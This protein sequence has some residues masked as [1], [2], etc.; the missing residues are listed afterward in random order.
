M[1]GSLQEHPDQTTK[2]CIDTRTRDIYA[3]CIF[4]LP[5]LH[6]C[7]PHS[8]QVRLGAGIAATFA[9][10]PSLT[11]FSFIAINLQDLHMQSWFF[12]LFTHVYASEQ[13]KRVF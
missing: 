4:A 6:D 13:E 2:Y 11:K 5:T 7:I 1:V 3:K 9:Y 8:Y 10:T 12:S